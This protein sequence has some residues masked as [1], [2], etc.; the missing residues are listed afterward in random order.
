MVQE[1][2][3]HAEDIDML[4]DSSPQTCSRFV[5]DKYQHTQLFKESYCNSD[6]MTVTV[7]GQD[8]GCGQDLYVVGLSAADVGKPLNRWKICKLTWNTTNADNMEWCSY[9]C[10]CSGGCEEVML[11]RWPKPLSASTWTLCDIS[12]H[13][14]GT[15]ESSV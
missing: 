15:A 8:M 5:S 10:D 2:G 1:G 11:L 14:N 6:R 9:D 4:R 3:S 7:V 13:C 12:E